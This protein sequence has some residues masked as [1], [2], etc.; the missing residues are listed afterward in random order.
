[1]GEFGP[2]L[3][4]WQGFIRRYRK[5]YPHHYII[6]LGREEN[7]FLY[8]SADEYWSY[9]V[10]EKLRPNFYMP[11][12]SI[13]RSRY[14]SIL[15]QLQSEYSF[16][17]IMD[18]LTIH[19][20]GLLRFGDPLYN[21]SFK[22]YKRMP[23]EVLLPPRTIL[24]Y[25]RTREVSKDKNWSV[26]KYNQLIS[27]LH[28]LGF[29]VFLTGGPDES[30]VTRDVPNIW[31]HNVH[32]RDWLRVQ[33][34]LLQSS[35]LSICP[36]SGTGF[37]PILCKTPTV[38]FGSPREKSRY[39]EDENIFSTKIEYISKRNPEVQEVLSSVARIINEPI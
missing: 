28:R 36:E 23:P 11:G 16:D 20:M 4:Y 5:T 27:D 33:F 24:L 15:Y 30:P 35:L 19:E 2:E 13:S 38:I 1:M 10:D 26:G 18:P 6:V 32:R 29:R 31:N 3:I 14:S 37:L 22:L 7:Q 17:Y 25:Q 8:E 34:S 21:Q 12:P 39:T 9:R